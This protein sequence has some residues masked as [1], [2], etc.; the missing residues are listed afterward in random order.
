MFGDGYFS[1]RYEDMLE[2]PF[3]QACKLWEFL[4]VQADRS[5]EKMVLDELSSNPDEE[6]Q[7]RRSEDIASFLP[8]GQAG[9]WRR[10]FT[11][12]DKSIF[13]EEAGGMLIK[14]GYEEGL[15]W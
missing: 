13:K 14:W 4:G 12:R 6:W 3:E 5:L 2:D 9:N 7:A 10:L 1:L 11:A 8:K 15:D